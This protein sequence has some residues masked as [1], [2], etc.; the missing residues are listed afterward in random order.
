[1]GVIRRLESHAYPFS[2]SD[3][4]LRDYAKRIVSTKLTVN[5]TM[6]YLDKLP[7]FAAIFH[8]LINQSN[9]IIVL[10]DVDGISLEKWQLG[11]DLCQ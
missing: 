1:M 11:R 8:F 10:I 4:P 7:K 9:G 5:T 3:P 2:I 6:V